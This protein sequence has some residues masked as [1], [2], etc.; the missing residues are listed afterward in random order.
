MKIYAENISK[1][2]TRHRRNITAVEPVGFEISGGLTVILG[3]SGSGKTTLLN[4]LA[5]LLAPNTGSVKYDTADIYALSDSELSDFRSRHIGYI[6]QGHSLVGSLTVEENILLPAALA[7]EPQK[8]YAQILIEELGLGGLKNAYPKELSGGEIR[9]AAIARA[10]INSPEVIFADEPT[11][12]LDDE[13]TRQVFGLLKKA[14]E[15]GKTV[16]AVTHD[17]SAAD[18]AD[19]VYR[20][21]AG[22]L[23]KEEG[24]KREIA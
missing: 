8:E 19:N 22:V 3:R 9:R 17:S 15:Q 12:D 4:I 11:N 7:G 10:L 21:D 6:P 18:Y 14:A 23:T 1:E 13:N 20:M 2:Y 5:G 16:I 24:H